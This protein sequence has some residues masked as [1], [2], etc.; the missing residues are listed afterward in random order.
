MVEYPSPQEL[1]EENKA[2]RRRV[3]KLENHVKD[4]KVLTG[5]AL[6]SAFAVAAMAAVALTANAFD[7]AEPMLPEEPAKQTPQLRYEEPV[8]HPFVPAAISQP[9]APQPQLRFAGATVTAYCICERCCGKTPDHPAYGITRS[10]RV[11]EPYVS[12]AVDPD[13]IALGETVYLDFGDG[14]LI[15]CRADDTGSAINGSRIDWC[16]PDHQT[17]LQFGVRT[18]DVYVEDGTGGAA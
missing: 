17:A 18:A 2:L 16:M 9:T 3:H 6:V 1:W 10:G 4:W 11:A 7:P 12:V 8:Q 5:A 15:E 13:E 14:L